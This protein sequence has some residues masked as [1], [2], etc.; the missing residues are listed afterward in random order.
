MKINI[1]YKVYDRNKLVETGTYLKDFPN[2]FSLENP[3]YSSEIAEMQEIAMIDYVYNKT[4]KLCECGQGHVQLSDKKLDKIYARM[5][6]RLSI[7]IPKE[8]DIMGGV[9]QKLSKTKH[10]K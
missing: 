9:K 4:K 1:E 6:V 7:V 5:S 2:D 3:D 8:F 10:A